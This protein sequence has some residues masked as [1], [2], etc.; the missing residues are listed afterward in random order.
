MELSARYEPLFKLPLARDI[1]N[2][3]D[4]EEIYSKAEVEYWRQLAGVSNVI[5]TG[6]RYSVKSFAVSTASCHWARDFGHRVL[7]TRYTMASAGDSIIPEFNEK[8]SMLGYYNDFNITKD[9]ITAKDPKNPAKIV[10]KGIK[11]SAGNMTASLKSLKDFSCFILDEGEEMPNFEDWEKISLSIRATDVQNLSVIVMNPTVRE[12]WVHVE[13]FEGRGV[14]EG[15][16]GIKGNTLYI[17]TTYKDCPEEFIPD[18]ILAKFKEAEK[19]YELYEN[20]RGDE[21]ELLPKRTVRLAKWYKHVVLGGWLDRAE[22]V[23]YE[24]WEIGT[25]DTALPY[26]YGLDFGSNDPDALV[27]VAV[28]H[29]RMRIYVKEVYF[30]NNTGTAQLMEILHRR[31][32]HTDLIIGDSAERRIIKDFQ[33]GMNGP[34]GDWLGGVNIRPSKKKTVQIG[35]KTIQGYTIVVDPLSTNVMKALRNYV[36]HD[37][38]SETPRH[39]WSDL[40]DAM[41]YAVLRL[42]FY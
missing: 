4:F 35:I 41:R 3:P 12:H 6:G 28:D 25:F 38:R 23:I 14:P 20:T 34:N 42:I 8:I 33:R 15:F 26:C 40:L 29:N 10:F 1:V 22:G 24:D 39:D 32:G 36:W 30:K 21:R 7:F 16:N 37:K 13:F 9:R 31:V 27:K 19:L 5:I 2:D 18:N 17:H 11:T